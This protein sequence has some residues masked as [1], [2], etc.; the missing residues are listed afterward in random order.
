MQDSF[1][2]MDRRRQKFIFVIHKFKFPI[3][4]AIFIL[5]NMNTVISDLVIHQPQRHHRKDTII[6]HGIK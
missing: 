4:L 1:Q 2:F 3:P 6:K 5:K